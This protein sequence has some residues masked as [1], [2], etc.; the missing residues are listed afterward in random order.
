MHFWAYFCFGIVYQLS[1]S[2][3]EQ[4]ISIFSKKTWIFEL[5]MTIFQI[6]I[7]WPEIIVFSCYIAQTD[8]NLHSVPEMNVKIRYTKCNIVSSRKKS[9]GVQKWPKFFC[10]FW[11]CAICVS[12]KSCLILKFIPPNLPAKILSFEGI[13]VFISPKLTEVDQFNIGPFYFPHTVV[14]KLFFFHVTSVGK[15]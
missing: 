7:K 10:H 6:L 12:N 5:K 11:F 3:H 1:S 4:K 9:P 8:R 13:S 15:A 2:I 14:R